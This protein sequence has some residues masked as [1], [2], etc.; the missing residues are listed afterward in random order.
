M[1]EEKTVSKQFLIEI[2]SEEAQQNL[3]K[4]WQEM[5]NDKGECAR[6]RRCETPTEAALCKSVLRLRMLLPFLSNQPETLAILA[7][8][9]SHVE[10]DDAGASFAKQLAQPKEVG[11]KPLVSE[12]RFQKMMKSRD[13]DEF[14]QSLRRILQVM[15]KKANV[16]SLADG[17]IRWGREYGKT[18]EIK[19]GKGLNFFWSKE[20]FTEFIKHEN[21]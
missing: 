11:G 5:R 7:G 16:L 19:P 6:L 13:W 18:A 3:L 8:I 1:T 21:K 2:R 17:I 4:W 10:I 14:Y 12:H 15:R 9:L 20:F